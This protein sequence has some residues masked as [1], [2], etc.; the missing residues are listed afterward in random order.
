M[1]HQLD[2]RLLGHLELSFASKNRS[3]AAS[4]KRATL[5]RPTAKGPL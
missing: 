5:P 4:L 3:A 2:V 1:P